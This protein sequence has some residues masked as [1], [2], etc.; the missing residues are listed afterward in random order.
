MLELQHLENLKKSKNLLAFSAGGDSSA[1]LFLLLENNIK[2]D[3]AIV[4]YNIR[5]QSK[6]EVI[7]ANELANKYNF[8]CFVHHAQTIN[9]NFEAKAR[10]IRYSFFETIISK[11]NYTNLL[12]A[13]HLGDRLEWMLMQFCKGAGCAELAGMRSLQKRKNYT[14]VRPLLNYEKEEL[15]TFLNANANKYFEDET[16]QDQSYKRNSFRH[17]IAIPL[18]KEYKAGIKKSFSY[19][20][21]DVDNLVKDIKIKKINQFAYFKSS[22]NKRND[23]YNIDKYIKTLGY[24]ITTHERKLLKENKTS[25]ISRKFIINQEHGYIFIAPYTKDI[26]LSKE[27]KEKMRRLKIEPKLRFYLASDTEAVKFLSLLLA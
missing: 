5:E 10:D 15:L 26:K 22:N 14:L 25:V 18:L 20:D 8:K 23:I 2:F 3:I 19:I 7:Y 6:D 24:I 21:E 4:D 1:L 17:K 11:Y 27:F 9:S 16:N 12:T 13:H